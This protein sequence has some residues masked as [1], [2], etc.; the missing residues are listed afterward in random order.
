M[1]CGCVNENQECTC[2]DWCTCEDCE[3]A[4]CSTEWISECECGNPTCGCFVEE[5]N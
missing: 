2:E 5:E 4:E 1:V 3:C